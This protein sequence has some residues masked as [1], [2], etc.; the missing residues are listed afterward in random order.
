MKVAIITYHRA[1]NYG[2][3]LQAYALNHYFWEQGSEAYTIDY[4]SEGQQATYTFYEKGHSIMTLV[5]NF[6]TFIYRKV[7]RTKCNCFD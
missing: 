2:S 7:L 5:R 3:A 1:L 4:S 6:F